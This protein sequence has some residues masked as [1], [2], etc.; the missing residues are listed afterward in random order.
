MKSSYLD[1]FEFDDA[2]SRIDFG[3]VQKWLTETYWSPGIGIDEVKR[4]AFHSTLVVG[5]YMGLTQVGYMRLVS[6]KT[7]FGYI[8]DVYVSERFRKKGIAQNIVEF[9]INNPELRDV[10]I[11]LL[12]TRDGHSVYSKIGFKPLPAPENWMI[13]KKPTPIHGINRLT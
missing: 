11:W 3:L 2:V 7:R 10:Y 13:L 1:I 5:C 12:G 8:M 9:A 6:D 4:G